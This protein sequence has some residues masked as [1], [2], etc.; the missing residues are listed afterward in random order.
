[1]KPENDVLSENFLVLSEQLSQYLPEV[2]YAIT[3]TT[4]TCTKARKQNAIPGYVVKNRLTG[5]ADCTCC[6]IYPD[7]TVQWVKN[8]F[9][10]HILGGNVTDEV[11]EA[12]LL[13]EF[14]NIILGRLC[15][16]IQIKEEH[17]QIKIPGE[18][19]SHLQHADEVPAGDQETLFLN[20]TITVNQPKAEKL[21]MGFTI[22]AQQ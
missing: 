15:A 12:N 18:I 21:H 22:A 19:F 9:I 2:F 14:S 1:M 11:G 3:G 10:H 13:L 8:C 16:R 20:T 6:M 5:P 4:C 7:S 17:P